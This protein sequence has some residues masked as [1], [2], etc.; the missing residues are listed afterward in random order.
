MME[1]KKPEATACHLRARPLV[2]AHQALCQ[3]VGS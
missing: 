3:K 1:E 2:V